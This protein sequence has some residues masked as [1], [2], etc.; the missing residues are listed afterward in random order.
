MLL[1]GLLFSGLGCT[2]ISE[3]QM[4]SDEQAIRELFDDQF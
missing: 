2:H 4:K 1:A 3:G